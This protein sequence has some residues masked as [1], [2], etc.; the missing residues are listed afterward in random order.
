MDGALFAATLTA[1]L[2]KVKNSAAPFLAN[3]SVKAR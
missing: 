1:R 2:S 3:S